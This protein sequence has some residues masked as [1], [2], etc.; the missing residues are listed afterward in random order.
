MDDDERKLEGSHQDAGNSRANGQR[1][2]PVAVVPAAMLMP[3]GSADA[4]ARRAGGAM[5]KPVTRSAQNCR[6]PKRA[7]EIGR[8]AV[9]WLT[10]SLSSSTAPSKTPRCRPPDF[11]ATSIAQRP[12]L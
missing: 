8:L 7:Y 4:Q 1:A 2:P 6:S 11:S 5:R 10:H 12:V 9:A 3:P